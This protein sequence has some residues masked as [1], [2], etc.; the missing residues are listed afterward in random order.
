MKPKDLKKPFKWEDRR[1]LM[2][3]GM[4]FVPEYY[5]KHH[6]WVPQPLFAEEKP[7]AVE[8]CAGNGAWILEKALQHPEINWIAVDIRFDRAR[9]IWSKMRNS[10]LSNLLVVCGEALTFSKHYLQDDTLQET[11]INFPD[12]WPKEKH[13]KHRLIQERF[14]KELARVLK[15]EGKVVLVTDHETYYEQ[16]KAE[17]AKVPSWKLSLYTNDWPGYGTS[18]FDHLF[19]GKGCTIHYLQFENQK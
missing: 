19:R 16:M 10:N 6:E 9:K 4:L 11:Y 3:E 17:V 13:A 8:Y 15:K 14:V 18:Y 2:H 12:P 5:D 1:P 7:I